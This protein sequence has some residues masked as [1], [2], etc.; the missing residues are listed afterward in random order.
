MLNLNASPAHALKSSAVDLAWK[1]LIYDEL[2]QDIISPL[3]TVKELRDLGVTLHVSVNH[4]Q[5]IDHLSI[6]FCSFFCSSL[7]SDRDPVDEIAAV[8]FLMPTEENI[9]RVAKVESSS[10]ATEETTSTF[11]SF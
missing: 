7:K 3:L 11:C 6:S 5:R 10:S 1:V 2:G 9:T 4:H 8:Y